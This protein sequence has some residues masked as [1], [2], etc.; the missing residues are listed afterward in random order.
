MHTSCDTS[1]ESDKM[2]LISMK[3]TKAVIPAAGL[4]TR[5]L[6]FTKAV[7]KEMLPLVNKPAIQNVIEEGLASGIDN[8]I[9]IVNT[10]KPALVNHFA[11]NP[12]LEETLKARGKEHLLDD[13]NQIVKAAQFSYVEQ[14]EQLGLGHAILMAKDKID[15]EYFGIFLPD[16][17]IDGEEP[18]L[19]QLIN[20][21]Q[22]YNASVIAVIEVPTEKV[23]SYGVVAYSDELEDGVYEITE[24]VEKP[25]VEKAPSN[26]AI[27]GRYILSPKIFASLEITKPGAGNEIQL[28]DGIA[29]MMKKGERVLAYKIK[30]TRYDIGKPEGW[31]KANMS[32][33]AKDPKYKNVIKYFCEELLSSL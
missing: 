11:P 12:K 3:I 15:N 22:K 32:F 21:A 14:P 18:G 33:A 24:L 2:E 13:I 8:F 26:L 5:F 16:D 28:T 6:P 9:V 1:I 31:L 19:K 25:P 29:D 27:I 20:V 7:P 4:G 23:S 17:I 30:G 10:D